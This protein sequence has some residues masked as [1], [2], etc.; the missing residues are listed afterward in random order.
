MNSHLKQILNRRYFLQGAAA[1]GIA[2]LV[3][4]N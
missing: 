1:S 2:L 4:A 3:V